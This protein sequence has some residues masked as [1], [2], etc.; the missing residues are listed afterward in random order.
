MEK[1]NQSGF[2]YLKIIKVKAVCYALTEHKGTKEE[3]DMAQ[4]K[5]EYQGAEGSRLRGN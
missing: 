3:K 4:V 5:E 1:I 2:L